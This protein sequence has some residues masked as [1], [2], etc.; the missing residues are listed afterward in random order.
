MKN[1][2]LIEIQLHFERYLNTFEIHGT[3]NFSHFDQH[4]FYAEII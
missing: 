2:I 3:Y 4:I 1:E